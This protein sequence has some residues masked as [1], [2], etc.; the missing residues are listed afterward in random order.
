LKR[1]KSKIF[2]RSKWHTQFFL[3]Y[4]HHIWPLDVP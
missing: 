1:M 4:I 2:H 3:M